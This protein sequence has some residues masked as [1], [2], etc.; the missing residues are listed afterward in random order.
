MILVFRGGQNFWPDEG[1]L[2]AARDAAQALLARHWKLAGA[3]LFA[4]ADHVLF[5][6]VGL[7]VALVEAWRGSFSPPWEAAYLALFSAGAIPLIWSIARRMGSGEDEALWAAFL[8]AAA[9]SLFFDCRHLFPYDPSLFFM[10]L[11]L[12]L[13]AGRRPALV[14]LGVGALVAFGFLTYN[15]Y[16]LMGA[17]VFAIHVAFGGSGLRAA[18]GRSAYAAAGFFLVAGLVVGAGIAFSPTLLVDYRSFSGSVRQGNFF[19]GY[20]VVLGY[21][22]S[23]ERLLVLVWLAAFVRFVA[24]PP[25]GASA[26]ARAWLAGLL[27]VVGGL[28]FFSDVVP[29]FM[30]Y[31]RLV[32]QAVP[33]LC[34]GAG[35]GMAALL[36]TGRERWSWLPAVAAAS[37]AALAAW[38]FSGPFRIVYPDQ[39]LRSAQ[40]IMKRD[41]AKEFSFYKLLFAG[42]LWGQ[43]L[44]VGTGNYG[45]LLRRPNPE[46][47]RPYQ[48]EGFSLA[49]R[50]DINSHDVS[51]RLMKV[52]LSPG[53][54]DVD[55]GNYPGPVGIETNLAPQ[56]WGESDPLIENGTTGAGDVVLITYDDPNHVSFG[57]D[58]WGSGLTQS[59][60]VPI[61]YAKRHK[62]LILDGALLPPAESPIYKARPDLQALRGQLIVVLDGQPVFI[63]HT[64]FFDPD[65]TRT[66]LGTNFIGASSVGPE[67]T[68]KVA[69]L[70][71]VSVAS[72]TRNTP[73][74]A[75]S[76][77]A[78][79][80][81][82]E[83]KGAVGP[84]RIRFAAPK[85][86]I[87]QPIVSLSGGGM[88]VVVFVT[89]QG[90][91]L[92]RAGI[93]R[94]GAGSV[95]S[96][97]I[98]QAFGSGNVLEVCLGSLLPAPPAGIY[99]AFPRLLPMRGE[100]YIRLNGVTAV[101]TGMP[102]GEVDPA[103]VAF[104]VNSV[105]S[106]ACIEN[107]EGNLLAIS[108]IGPGDLPMMGSRL[109]SLVENPDPH[110]KGFTGSLAVS[111]ELPSGARGKREP[112]VATGTKGADDLLY[113]EYLD[114]TRVRFGYEHAPY[115]PVV[116]GA[117]AV[118]AD[119][120][121][122][123]LLSMGSLFPPKD[124]PIYDE[125]TDL[126][127]LRTFYHVGVNG[128]PVLH[129][130]AE[131][132]PSDPSG[133]E[134]G[135]NPT[136]NSLVAD[137]FGG[138]I[139]GVARAPDRAVFSDGH[140]PAGLGRPG[141]GG[142]PGAL[143]L[144][145]RLGAGA[146]G[147]TEP[148]LTTGLRGVGD[149]LF[150][151]YLGNGMARVGQDHWGSPLL[152]SRPFALGDSPVHTAEVSLGSLYPAAG[153]PGAAAAGTLPARTIVVF[154]GRKVL[155][156]PQASHPS[157]PEYIMAGVNLIGATTAPP[158]LSGA[159]LSVAAAPLVSLGGPAEEGLP[160]PAK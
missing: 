32:R 36:R 92:L 97:P 56:Y 54:G 18:A 75:A 78:A 48:Y 27:I 88:K 25:A 49:Q 99:S 151:E 86:A 129:G 44:D 72:I 108:E 40:A 118:P 58:H 50:R 93:D 135:A 106:S 30:V 120:R 61:D 156:A 124:A 119:R 137:R 123:L 46:Q 94:D 153:E 103:K 107:Y 96:G 7:P 60:P 82:Q 76:R 71:Q 152:L 146:K 79:H 85:T 12:F 67:F 126:D 28:V 101:L 149:V 55:W 9:N 23:S 45:V 47:F 34:L 112:L 81:S 136:G 157:R 80:R 51:M 66:T 160:G 130:Y 42:S 52:A 150:L 102:F 73:V 53:D 114:D 144:G 31:G 84:L 117:V 17:S 109:V 20:R 127:S 133:A 16:W 65:V 95:I 41:S 141:W 138:F 90:D 19:L 21:L 1:R 70:F 148:L 139:S 63:D 77:I 111:L 4:H 83:W 11:A 87:A 2:G 68:G 121:L 6:L 3:D 59:A 110:W 69:A 100:A 98:P 158:F 91:G 154:D 128:A 113:V 39:F 13:G 142:Y 74:F 131:F 26:R 43:K 38:N 35:G 89:R 155:D 104:G 15:G 116:S 145:L 8:A 57:H 29:M 132:A 5:R 105:G 147:A 115:P 22:W 134:V 143:R 159:V 125:E 122:Q 24:S 62:I 10:L 37:V 33:Y 14:S 140:I 64:K